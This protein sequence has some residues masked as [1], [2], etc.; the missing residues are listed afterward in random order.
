MRFQQFETIGFSFLL[1]LLIYPAISSASPIT[2]TDSEIWSRINNLQAGLVKDESTEY[3]S[4]AILF[5]E[6]EG[7]SEA[8]TEINWSDSDTGAV[9]DFDFGH[10]LVGPTNQSFVMA[11]SQGSIYFTANEATSY[12]LSGF[13]ESEMALRLYNRTF[14]QDLT[15]GEY[16]FLDNSDS[17]STEIESFVLGD[18]ND[19]DYAN[20]TL[21]NLGKI[22]SLVRF[23]DI[24][25]IKFS[26][27]GGI[28]L[29]GLYLLATTSVK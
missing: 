25:V 18:A 5:T 9:L 6:H 27:A 14:L 26:S 19:A 10:Y 4:R 28:V 17:R 7:T 16:L 13:Y 2:I 12:S 20:E 8:F 3:G 29:S 15:T 24:D 1:G 23:E 11:A 22:S 21:G